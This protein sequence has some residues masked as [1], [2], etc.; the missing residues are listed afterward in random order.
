MIEEVDSTAFYKQTF[1]V[2]D[3]GEARAMVY[4]FKK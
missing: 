3:R 4:F 1:K 2:K